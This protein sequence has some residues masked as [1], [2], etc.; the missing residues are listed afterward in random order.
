M[1]D[2]KT[3]RGRKKKKQRKSAT[4]AHPSSFL[5]GYLNRHNSRKKIDIATI[6]TNSKRSVSACIEIVMLLHE[7]WT[8]QS[9]YQTF[10]NN[11]NNKIEKKKNYIQQY[12]HH[13]NRWHRRWML[14]CMEVTLH[15]GLCIIFFLINFGDGLHSIQPA[16]ALSS[17]R[18]FFLFFWSEIIKVVLLAYT[19]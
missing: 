8:S 4:H 14:R 5:H 12:V 15:F 6:L 19:I 18:F 7:W 10:I 11:S 13:L 3:I 16:N 17:I 1:K 2:R 9:E